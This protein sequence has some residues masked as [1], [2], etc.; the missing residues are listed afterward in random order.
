MRFVLFPFLAVL[1]TVGIRRQY[2]MPR[3]MI[4]ALTF[5]IVSWLLFD[6]KVYAVHSDAILRSI[7]ETVLLMAGPLW[8]K[9]LEVYSEG[10]ELRYSHANLHCLIVGPICEEYLFR[11]LPASIFQVPP[12]IST[13]TFSAVHFKRDEWPRTLVQMAFTFVFACW[14]NG[15]YARNG[16][17][18]VVISHALCNAIGFPNLEHFKVLPDWGKLLLVIVQ[19]ISWTLL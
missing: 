12:W 14:A 5:V 9:L 3:K 11:H 18:G 8:L 6:R 13:F 4:F 19:L 7:A 17:I 16:L 2:T 15:V 1:Y 10:L